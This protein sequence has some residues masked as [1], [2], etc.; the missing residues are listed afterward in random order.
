MGFLPGSRRITG[1]ISK[2]LETAAFDPALPPAAD[3]AWPRITVVTPSFNQAP[4]LEKTILSIHNQG[5][6]NLEHIIVDGGSTDG[7]VDI[8]MKYEARLAHWQSRPDAG[9]C[10]A[11]NQG[12]ARATGQY[13]TWINSDDLLLPGALLRMGDLIRRDPDVD[14]FYGNQ[15]E[16]DRWDRVTKRVY[17]IDFDLKDFLYEVHII[18]HQQSALWR[19]DLFRELSGLNDCAYAMDY[20]LFYRMVRRGIRWRRIRDFQAAFRIYSDSLTGSG[21]VR[22]SRSPTVDRIFEEATGRPR[23]LWDRTVWRSFHKARRFLLEPRSLMCAVEHRLWQSMAREG[24]G[25]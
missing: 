17:T 25:P 20:D 24:I 12:A 4:Y 5:Y 19:V 22:R 10:D 6:P 11:I 18:I 3:P 2:F 16:V 7:S 9:Q 14:L 23:T 15:V 13:M 1:Q 21:E 8:I